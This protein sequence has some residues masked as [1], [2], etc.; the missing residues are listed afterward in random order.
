M[1]NVELVTDSYQFSSHFPPYS[2][3]YVLYSYYVKKHTAIP[4]KDKE[5]QE[6]DVFITK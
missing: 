1:K 3:S 6:R 5:T 2:S 4:E